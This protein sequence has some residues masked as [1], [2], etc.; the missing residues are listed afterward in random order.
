MKQLSMTDDKFD[1]EIMRRELLMMLRR[2][3]RYLERFR[4]AINPDERRDFDKRISDLKYIERKYSSVS[5]I[6]R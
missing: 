5:D 4:N 2:S 6:L 3:R 1:P